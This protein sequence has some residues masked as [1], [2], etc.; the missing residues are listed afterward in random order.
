MVH[1]RASES[2]AKASS[3]F[4][5]EASDLRRE[6]DLSRGRLKEYPRT[7][8]LTLLSFIL[9]STSINYYFRF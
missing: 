4:E 8:I 3:R 6:L 7:S 1:S 2:F 5:A 9:F